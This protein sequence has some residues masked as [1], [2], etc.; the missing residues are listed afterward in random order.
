VTAADQWSGGQHDK[1][2][3][4]N[5]ASLDDQKKRQ[6]LDQEHTTF[7]Q[8]QFQDTCFFILRFTMGVL[9]ILSIPATIFICYLIIFDPH[10][11]AIVKRLAAGALFVSIIGLMVYVWKVFISRAAVSRL[12]PVTKS[13]EASLTMMD[14]EPANQA[15]SNA[16]PIM[17][18]RVLIHWI[19]K[20]RLE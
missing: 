14:Q 16:K 1:P 4:N 11:D 10:Q 9:A 13:D 17:L 2:S 7:K 6:Q 3:A 19:L 18:S 20:D 12:K 8:L 15:N 5:E